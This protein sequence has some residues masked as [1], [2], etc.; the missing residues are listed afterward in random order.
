MSPLRPTSWSLRLGGGAPLKASQ[1]DNL[2]GVTLPSLR[3]MSVKD[4]LFA[5]YLQLAREKTDQRHA[6]GDCDNRITA[7]IQ[8]KM[9]SNKVTK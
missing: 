5:E 8:R 7:E 9:Q 1:M 2:M 6:G 4:I 3:R